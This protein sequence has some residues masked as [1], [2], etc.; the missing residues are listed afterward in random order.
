[1]TLLY[2]RRRR[3]DFLRAVQSGRVIRQPGGEDGSPTQAMPDRK[4]LTSLPVLGNRW[5]QLADGQLVELR[6][7]E[8]W[9][10][11]EGEIGHQPEIW[12]SMVQEEKAIVRDEKSD[13]PV[14]EDVLP[15]DW[16]VSVPSLLPIRVLIEY[17]PC[18]SSHLRVPLH[19][20]PPL[21]LF[22]LHLVETGVIASSCPS[23][24]PCPQSTPTCNYHPM[25]LVSKMANCHLSRSHPPAYRCAY[26]PASRVPGTRYRET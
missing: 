4:G 21:G 7:N 12:D 11:T 18:H 2:K 10:L 1:M 5:V 25:T 3:R 17:S 24:L 6:R 23:L 26:Q 20:H 15:D 14:E 9:G 22:V 19:L 16:R 13:V 8:E